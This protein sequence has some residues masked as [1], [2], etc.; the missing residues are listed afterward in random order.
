VRIEFI[1]QD[2][3][4]YI[5]PLFEEFFR[6]YSQVCK[7]E[8]I[9]CCRT[10]GNRPRRQLLLEL[11]Q[12]YGVTGLMRL[13]SRVAV[14]RIVGMWPMGRNAGRYFSLSQLCRAYDVPYQTIDN[15]NAAD[16]VAAVKK[17]NCDVIVSVACPYI[18]KKAF[19]EIPRLG[20]IN[21][22]HAPLPRYKGMMP[23]FWQMYHGEQSV[24][25]T[26]H[27]MAEKV[28]EGAALLQEELKINSEET[29]DTVIR[30]SKRHA[31]HA[32]AS[33]LQRIASGSC[34]T[35]PLN[36]ERGSYFTFPTR[37]EI[38]EFQQRGLRAI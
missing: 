9:A 33:V 17:R 13:L 7:V 4:I 12:L 3:P 36:S 23:T 38:C 22:H 15:P 1:T 26:V 18:L 8:G 28:D 14:G 24:G 2:D 27:Y 32:L 35:I 37:T 30:R 5:L 31:A 16:F 21:I 25:L 20:C 29:L 10:M 6:H 11:K 19:L 34:T